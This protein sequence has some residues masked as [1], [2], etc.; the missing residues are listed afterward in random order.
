MGFC[1][2]ASAIAASAA[3][4]MQIRTA[5]SGVRRMREGG[6]VPGN[7]LRG[8]SVPA[9]LQPGEGVIPERIVSAL[10]GGDDEPRPIRLMVEFNDERFAEMV[11]ISLTEGQNVNIF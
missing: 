8:D 7:P 5:F 4:A 6:I 2:W 3:V 1:G 10:R 11:N 9:L